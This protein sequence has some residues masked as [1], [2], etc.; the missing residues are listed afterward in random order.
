MLYSLSISPLYDL[1]SCFLSY[2]KTHQ[3]LPHDDY[4]SDSPLIITLIINNSPAPPVIIHILQSQLVC[5]LLAFTT[6]YMTSTIKVRKSLMLKAASSGRVECFGSTGPSFHVCFAKC[7]L[8]LIIVF[9]CRYI[10]L[11][12]GTQV[13]CFSTSKKEKKI[14]MTNGA[15]GAECADD[16]VTIR[17]LKHI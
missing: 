2:S 11:C 17:I 7:I 12:N 8:Y 1:C 15:E 10:N 16:S 4:L 13:T 5:F 6:I 9:C 3:W 14:H